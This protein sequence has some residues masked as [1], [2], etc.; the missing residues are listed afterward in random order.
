M[1]PLAI[2]AI[3]GLVFAGKKLSEDNDDSIVTY[4][5]PACT[6]KPPTTRSIT[7]RDLDLMSNAWDH[8]KDGFD[9]RNTNP[10]LGR[11]I[12]DWRLAPKDAI[13]SLQDSKMDTKTF[14]HGQPVYNMYEREYITNKLNNVQPIERINV[15]PGLGYGSNVAA[16]G[17]FH[18]FFRAL[19]TNINEEKLTTLEGRNGPPAHFIPSGGPVP[20]GLVSHEAK[21]TK[22][23]YQPPIQSRAEGQGGAITKPEKRPEFSK[24]ARSTIRQQTGERKDTLS[25]GPGQYNVYQPYAEGG[26]VAYTNKALTRSSDVRSKPDRPGNAG[27][28]NV[29]NDPVN[30]V[31]LPSS[32]RA[33]T[34]EFPVG[35]V[36]AT[37]GGRVQQ[38]VD[39]RFYNLNERKGQE[40]PYASKH[41]LDVA[42]QALE[43]N[44]IALPPLAVV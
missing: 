36:N 18:Q 42:I 37:T 17:G 28:M 43:G 34:T 14:P 19:P 16:A 31:G 33:E 40:N 15:G 41:S 8:D 2:A 6:S 35:P 38:Y 32:L 11:R 5:K 21:D 10:G 23:A 44:P 22:T 26:E 27:C 9:L 24:T 29:R 7:R 12:G 13:P 4:T 30:I 39:S 25:D 20:L 1:D 3:V